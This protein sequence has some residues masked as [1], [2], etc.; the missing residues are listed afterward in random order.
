MR[1]TLLVF[2]DKL[3]WPN[4]DAAVRHRADARRANTLSV[5]LEQAASQYIGRCL[6]LRVPLRQFGLR[7][8]DIHRSRARIDLD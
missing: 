8:S 6:S 1:E 4:V 5:F 7:E 2:I 3:G